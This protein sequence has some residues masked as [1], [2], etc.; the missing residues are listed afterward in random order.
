MNKKVDEYIDY[1][2]NE[3]EN[4]CIHRPDF[5]N[6]KKTSYKKERQ[7]NNSIELEVTEIYDY[8][9]GY[10][11]RVLVTTCFDKFNRP[12]S[13]SNTCY[14][15]DIDTD[16]YVQ[17]DKSNISDFGTIVL[18]YPKE[19][20]KEFNRYIKTLCTDH[21]IDRKI[22]TNVFDIDNTL[23]EKRT[24]NETNS[25]INTN[26]VELY[27]NG[28][29]SRITETTSIGENTTEYKYDS[30]NN[31]ILKKQIR[32]DRSNDIIH[33]VMDSFDYDE[34]NRMIK[35]NV[36]KRISEDNGVTWDTLTDYINIYAYYEIEG[37]K[38]RVTTNTTIPNKNNIRIYGKEE[39]SYIDFNMT[40][41][42]V[43]VMDGDVAST[44]ITFSE[45][46]RSL[47]VNYANIETANRGL[48]FI[49]NEY[50]N[51]DTVK[52]SKSSDNHKMTLEYKGIVTQEAIT[53]IVTNIFKFT[54]AIEPK[55]LFLISKE[56]AQIAKINLGIGY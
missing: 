44:A 3:F 41:R 56:V 39:D 28:L 31:I 46:Y 1:V 36:I 54:F 19:N 53:K 48:Y 45:D 42:L 34:N 25:Y 24:I 20:T 51:I 23:I 38:V 2:T 29:I 32:N 5:I 12:I 9:D 37:K 16:P 50:N 4:N 40:K 35:K 13:S 10:I 43:T 8:L 52:F 18:E 21:G 7:E 6:S 22:I 27:T 30:N 15:F 11:K 55:E 47:K 33:I 49:S 26:M 14:V 17:L